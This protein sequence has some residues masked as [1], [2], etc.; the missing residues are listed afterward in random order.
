MSAPELNTDIPNQDQ[1][2]SSETSRPSVGELVGLVSKQVSALIRGE[3]SL[4]KAKAATAGK[5]FALAIGLFGTVAVMAFY[6]LERLLRAAEYGIGEFVPMWAACLI[7]AGILLVIMIILALIGKS[8]IT[9]AT[10]D[11][12]APQEGLSKDAKAIKKGLTK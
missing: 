8:A 3:I 12:P 2:V 6:L 7:V 9:K 11:T 5:R 4:A 10:T 1:K